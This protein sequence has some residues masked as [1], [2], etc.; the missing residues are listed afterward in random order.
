[1]SAKRSRVR[2]KESGRRVEIEITSKSPDEIMT[3]IREMGTAHA[4]MLRPCWLL[5][6]AI[7]R[8]HRIVSRKCSRVSDKNSIIFLPNRP[9]RGRPVPSR[10]LSRAARS[11]GARPLTG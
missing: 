1:M 8:H 11:G 5:G 2:W 9:I 6:S 10:R 7:M 4:I 3:P